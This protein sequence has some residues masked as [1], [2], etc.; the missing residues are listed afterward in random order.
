MSAKALWLLSHLID[1]C[2]RACHR[3]T[4][5]CWTSKK[6]GVSSD[7]GQL[8]FIWV[9][10]DRTILSLRSHSIKS[11]RPSIKGD[12][13]IV[14]TLSRWE[15]WFNNRKTFLHDC[16]PLHDK[17]KAAAH[18]TLSSSLNMSIQTQRSSTCHEMPTPILHL[19]LFWHKQR[20]CIQMSCL[21]KCHKGFVPQRSEM[22]GLLQ[23]L[24]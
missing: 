22:T 5:K 14:D 13:Y 23:F 20:S 10:E 11:V 16:N 9:V 21:W 12:A 17:P 8:N 1:T 19:L 7:L 18:A 4:Q 3:V 2:C 15:P 6:N 24:W